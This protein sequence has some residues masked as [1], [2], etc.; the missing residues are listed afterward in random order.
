MWMMVYMIH[1]CENIFLYVYFDK[2]LTKKKKQ[3]MIV[4]TI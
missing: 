3:T 4:T 2:N 1:V